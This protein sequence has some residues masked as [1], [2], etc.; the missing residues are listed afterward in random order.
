MKALSGI[1]I[2]ASLDSGAA[3]EF[4]IITIWKKIFAYHNA[5]EHSTRCRINSIHT[6]LGNYLYLL[7]ATKE[8]SV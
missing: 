3:T 5:L 6:K 1:M 4:G 7:N 8:P 2:P